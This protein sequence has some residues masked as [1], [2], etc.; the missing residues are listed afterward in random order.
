MRSKPRVALAFEVDQR[1][2][3]CLE[4]QASRGIVRITRCLQRAL[5][6]P[7]SGEDE[8]AGKE[9]VVAALKALVLDLQPEGKE[10]HVALPRGLAVERLLELP[11]LKDELLGA[12]LIHEVERIIPWPLEA[13]H[14]GYQVLERG[15][16]LE[17]L[18]AVIR[19]EILAGYLSLFEKAGLKVTGAGLTD[20]AML[21]AYHETVGPRPDESRIVVGVRDATADLAWT[22]KGRVRFSR[23]FPLDPL[24][25]PPA[26]DSAGE[27]PQPPDNA[28]LLAAELG[29]SMAF[30]STLPGASPVK[31]IWLTGRLSPTRNRNQLLGFLTRELGIPV[32]VWPGE[33]FGVFSDAGNQVF[34]PAFMVC[35]GLAL[36]ALGR[37]IYNLNLHPS[38]GKRSGTGGAISS[39]P[40][41]LKAAV[42]AGITVILTGAGFGID[43]IA[44]QQQI[45]KARQQLGRLAP[46]VA[47]AKAVQ[48][49]YRRLQEEYGLLEERNNGRRYLELLRE[50]HRLMPEDSWVELLSLEGERLLELRGKSRSATEVMSLLQKSPY[51]KE[52]KFSAP[53]MSVTENGAS[54][55]AFRISGKVVEPN[56][57]R[58]WR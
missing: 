58:V 33:T 39:Q 12:A 55:E 56:G 51:L 35:Y 3:R 5:P 32:R 30:V 4:L 19:W 7:P 45:Q 2:V 21:N 44:K 40:F 37:G 38:A 50:L 41:W 28:E 1:E 16:R 42:L 47:E 52:L 17:V 54:Y 36:Q 46:R 43:T 6:A 23:D 8:A 57:G 26:P 11:P 15:D 48:A 31:G 29:R 22:Q 14:F 53:I 10:I 25:Q 18:V 9:R 24:S 49:E 34:A 13:V 20:L 27:E